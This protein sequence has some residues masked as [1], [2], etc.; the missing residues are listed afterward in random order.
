MYIQVCQTFIYW[1]CMT[2]DT[3]SM[4]KENYVQERIKINTGVKRALMNHLN[5][6]QILK[7]SYLQPYTN[8]R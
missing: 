3:T 6:A 4:I 8:K 2:Y 1:I 5:S 7:S